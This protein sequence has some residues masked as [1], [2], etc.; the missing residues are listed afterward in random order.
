MLNWYSIAPRVIRAARDCPTPTERID[1]DRATSTTPDRVFPGWRKSCRIVFIAIPPCICVA[2]GKEAD[3]SQSS[4]P[5]K[6][7][8]PASSIAASRSIPVQ[9]TLQNVLWSI[10]PHTI[11][12]RSPFSM[13]KP[14]FPCIE[15]FSTV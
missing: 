10:S 12:T 15:I 1:T 3:F 6:T 5:T 13:S 7:T 11:S 8:P 2:A 4:A 14:L 9:I